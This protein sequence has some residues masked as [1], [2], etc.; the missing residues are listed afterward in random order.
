MGF[1]DKIQSLFYQVQVHNDFLSQHEIMGAG[2][3]LTTENY[4]SPP[5]AVNEARLHISYMPFY[6]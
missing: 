2:G 1:V 5:S 3:F 6:H 4:L